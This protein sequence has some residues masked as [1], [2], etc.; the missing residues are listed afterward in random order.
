MARKSFTVS[1]GPVNVGTTAKT[2]LQLE[3][4]ADGRVA[5]RRIELAAMGNDV[6]ARQA[7]VEIVRQNAGGTATTMTP[8]KKTAFP[9]PATSTVRGDFSAEA[10][11]TGETVI[12]TTLRPVF[13]GLVIVP[14]DVLGGLEVGGGERLGI[15]ARLVTGQTAVD[16][17]AT[18]EFEE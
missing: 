16:M 15:R 8:V 2:I 7:I 1:S 3:P 11:T 17:Y 4:A 12:S 14:E 10:A 6:T 18:I 13:Q 9:E 5:V